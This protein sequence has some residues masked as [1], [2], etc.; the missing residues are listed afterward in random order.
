M[1][2]LVVKLTSAAVITPTS[3]LYLMPIPMYLHL[4][5]IDLWY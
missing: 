1:L 4:K 2:V 3:P 5:V